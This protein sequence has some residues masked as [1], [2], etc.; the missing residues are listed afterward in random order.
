MPVGEHDA[1]LRALRLQEPVDRVPRIDRALRLA[2][3]IDDQLKRTDRLHALFPRPPIRKLDPRGR[4]DLA[5]HGDIQRPRRTADPLVATG[6]SMVEDDLA[7]VC[8]PLGRPLIARRAVLLQRES[9]GL[10]RPPFNDQFARHVLQREPCPVLERHRRGHCP[11][12]QRNQPTQSPHDLQLALLNC[13]KSSQ[14]PGYDFATHSAP[15][16]V[17][18]RLA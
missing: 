8:V 14:K 3:R 5:R 1:T 16:I 13:S 10:A 11:C 12:N 17:T 4:V 2:D 18:G 7:L 6:T 9:H 15:S